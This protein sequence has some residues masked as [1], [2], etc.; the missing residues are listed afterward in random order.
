MSAPPPYDLAADF[1]EYGIIK[2]GAL[3]PYRFASRTSHGTIRWHREAA[4]A[5]RAAGK[6]GT[7]AK[8]TVSTK[9]YDEWLVSKGARPLAPSSAGLVEHSGHN[10]T[11]TH[12]TYAALAR[13]R[14]PRPVLAPHVW[15]EGR[16]GV[17]IEPDEYYPDRD[18]RPG[19]AAVWPKIHLVSSADEAHEL[20]ERLTTTATSNIRIRRSYVF[21]LPADL[22]D[23]YFEDRTIRGNRQRYT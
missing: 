11:T 15:G 2:R 1:G 20:H 22:A 13:C 14:W 23:A 17:Y 8:V 12:K 5:A 18:D 16:F 10:C 3:E 9:R 21:Q 6:R 4:H 19:A 7:T